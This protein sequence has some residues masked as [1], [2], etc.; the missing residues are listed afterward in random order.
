MS[1]VSDTGP[2]IA[3]AKV[4]QLTLLESLFGI[5]RVPPAVH[6][7]LFAKTGVESERLDEALSNYIQVAE[8]PELAS[9]I[10]LATL[11]LDAGEREAVALAQALNLPLLM[12]DQLGRHSARRLGLGVTGTVGVLI[13]AK[14]RGR[15]PAVRPVLEEMRTQGYWLSDELIELASKLA[16]E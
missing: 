5:V 13:E 1:I 11:A 8:R 6:R 4:N 3:L 9:E 12:D 7:E 15:L 14:R 10:Q 2:L 16:Q